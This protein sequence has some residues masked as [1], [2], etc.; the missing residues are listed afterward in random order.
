MFFTMT[1]NAKVESKRGW[2]RAKGERK[3]IIPPNG[4]QKKRRPGKTHCP[5]FPSAARKGEGGRENV[6]EERCDKKWKFRLAW[7]ATDRNF[8]PLSSAHHTFI[9]FLFKWKYNHYV[10]PRPSHKSVCSEMM[11][12]N[13]CT[14]HH[15]FLSVNTI[16]ISVLSLDEECWQ[17]ELVP[18][19]VS[20]SRSV[21]RP[22]SDAHPRRIF[23]IA[24][25][26]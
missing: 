23:I 14:E 6:F 9:S 26:S 25:Y 24:R 2:R 4:Q 21:F 5:I 10:L 19:L 11:I 17:P 13:V 7:R 16:F 22:P 20:H 1:K 8:F 3:S 18:R 12:W 15:D